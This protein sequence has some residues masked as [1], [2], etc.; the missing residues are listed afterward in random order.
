M[1]VALPAAPTARRGLVVPAE[2]GGR[3]PVDLAACRRILVVRLDFIGDWVLMLPFLANLR[4][5]APGAEITA[6]VLTRVYDLARA[7]R[8]VDR[9]VAVDPVEAGPVAF[10]G[11]D[12]ADVADFVADY[13]GGV[14]DLALVPR[15]DTDFNGALRIANGSGARQVIG[16]SEGCTPQRAVENRGDDRFYDAVLLDRGNAHEVEHKL[17]L[18]EAIGGRVSE[19]SL[20]LDLDAA[21]R[22]AADRFVTDAI[23]GDGRFL[24]VAPFAIGRKGLPPDVTADVTARLAR[25][26]DLPVV[27]IGSPVHGEEAAGFAAMLRR[28]AVSAIGLP[29][30]V[31]AALIGRATALVGMD[32]G[33]AHIAAAL[34]TPVSVV[35]AH[36]ESGAADHVGSP[37]RFRP[38]G[39]P[40]RIQIVQ[41]ATPLAPCVEGCEADAPHCI[42]QLDADWLTPR[43]AG[44]L[45]RFVPEAVEGVAT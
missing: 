12:E 7:C 40:A 10:F 42:T 30:G 39:D 33:P 1:T 2:G 31:S 25:E 14:F 3:L 41:P 19:R 16:F 29:L 11:R 43:I 44:F 17:G 4:A 28:S 20:R 18:L 24:A 36:P 38:W 5:S 6:V 35:F 45:A 21:D 27:V 37:E 23:S 13:T 34:G 8:F 26:L 22:A 32:S 15:W 9:V